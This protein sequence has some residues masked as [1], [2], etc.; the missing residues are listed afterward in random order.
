MPFTSKHNCGRLNQVE[1]INLT[2]FMYI[3][4]MLICSLFYLNCH[5]LCLPKK[6]R[7]CQ[8][9]NSCHINNLQT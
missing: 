1:L 3:H 8:Y 2:L 9:Y 7:T 4:I 5:K 6:I